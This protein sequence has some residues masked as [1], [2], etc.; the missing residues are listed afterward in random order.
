MTSE[1][2]QRVQTEKGRQAKSTFA[3]PSTASPATSESAGGETAKTPME[4]FWQVMVKLLPKWLLLP[5]AGL[6][7]LAGVAVAVWSTLPST[8]KESVVRKVTVEEY[9]PAGLFRVRAALGSGAVGRGM[10]LDLTLEADHDG[11]VWVYDVKGGM[12]SRV[13]PFEKEDVAAQRNR[14]RAGENRAIPG[15][16]DV[17]ALQAETYPGEE[18][19]IVIV[20]EGSN[21]SQALRCLATLRPDLTIKVSPIQTG[22][23]GATELRFKVD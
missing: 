13:Y 3:P 12:A 19:L 21:P 10:P 5:I 6:I 20:T 2:G 17:G 14:V 22:N 18:V 1:Q 7:V 11:Y 23:W 4:T 15:P 8:T 16:D 9:P